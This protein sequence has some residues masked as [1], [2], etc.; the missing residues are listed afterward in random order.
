MSRQPQPPQRQI[1]YSAIGP[2]VPSGYSIPPNSHLQPVSLSGPVVT[3]NIM[4]PPYAAPSSSSTPSQ[5]QGWVPDVYSPTFVSEYQRSINTA[6][7]TPVRAMPPPQVDF[8]KFVEHFA[9]R[10]FFTPLPPL[11]PFAPTYSSFFNGV[12]IMQMGSGNVGKSDSGKKRLSSAPGSP[13]LRKKPSKEGFQLDPSNYGAH[14]SDLIL[15]EI[16]TENQVFQGYNMYT[17]PV[18][19]H[20]ISQYLFQLFIPGIRE[21]T[22]FVQLGDMIKLR[23]IRPSQMQY[24]SGVFTG[25]EY[26]AYVYGMDKTVGYL[27]LRVDGLWIEIGGRFN[28]IFGVQ[29]QRW[30]GARRAVADV[31]TALTARSNGQTSV[32]TQT[33]EIASGTQS[34]FL[35]RMLFPEESDGIM[36]YGLPRGIFGRQWIDKELNYEQVSWEVFIRT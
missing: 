5:T 34:S 29:E 11:P 30:D 27:I 26:E 15:T 3:T 2:Q 20:D 35:R 21:N 31:G 19:P 14:F 8:V 28:V 13:E 33:N 23:Q 4:H 18:I 32:P 22:P 9:G 16:S 1:F 10:G 17:V 6:P 7:A 36:Q 24:P 12:G 25:F